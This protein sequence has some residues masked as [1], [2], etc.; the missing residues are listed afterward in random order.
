[1]NYFETQHK[2]DSIS[3][4]NE[5]DLTKQFTTSLAS[6][7][8]TNSKLS[9]VVHLLLILTNPFAPP[10]FR[11]CLD[12]G[13]EIL[14]IWSN[15]YGLEILFSYECLRRFPSRYTEEKPQTMKHGVKITLTQHELTCMSKNIPL[16][17][18][19]FHRIR[20]SRS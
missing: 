1:M 3:L 10:Q 14:A 9:L 2:K 6:G 20:E 4:Y 18:E 5:P 19:G 12:E 16:P 13:K 17:A 15:R 7:F 11:S 8:M